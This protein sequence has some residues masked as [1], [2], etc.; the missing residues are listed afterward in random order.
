MGA[1]SEPTVFYYWSQ[2]T[3]PVSVFNGQLWQ[4]RP[5]RLSEKKKNHMADC[6][7]SCWNVMSSNCCT[8]FSELTFFPIIDIYFFFF[9]FPFTRGGSV[10]LSWLLEP[11]LSIKK[12]EKK[13]T[14]TFICYLFWPVWSVEWFA[15]TATPKRRVLLYIS[16]GLLSLSVFYV[17]FSPTGNF[18]VLDWLVLL[19]SDCFLEIK[20]Y[21][22]QE[23]VVH[24]KNIM[25]RYHFSQ[26]SL[27][28]FISISI[29]FYTIWFYLLSA[30]T[31][32]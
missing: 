25:S 1:A 30:I 19:F 29:S 18:I 5:L 12:R 8:S 21:G 17:C 24:S 13:H 7:C 16:S 10:C 3:R 26:W 22:K 6:C 27:F 23:F 2:M 9:F 14:H 4:P 11:S 15:S 32:L 28:N 31:K 20:F